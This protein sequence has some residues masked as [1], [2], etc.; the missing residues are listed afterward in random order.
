MRTVYWA[1]SMHRHS[2]R[3]SC[4]SGWRA[5]ARSTRR[6]SSTTRVDDRRRHVRWTASASTPASDTS[7]WLL[8][9]IF[10]HHRGHRRD[11]EV[12]ARP[13][14]PALPAALP[15]ALLAW[16]GF[17]CRSAVGFFHPINAMLIFGLSSWIVWDEW[18]RRK[19][20]HGR[21]RP[22]PSRS[23]VGTSASLGRVVGAR[24]RRGTASS[25]PRRRR[26]SSGPAAAWPRLWQ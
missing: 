3:S 14:R 19:T 22:R 4:R 10:L 11:R 7:S 24:R 9:L 25:R 5:T 26:A 16:I 23:D 18:Q 2:R 6:T 15:P 20:A 21:G 17:E 13:A 1:W 12:A 8:G